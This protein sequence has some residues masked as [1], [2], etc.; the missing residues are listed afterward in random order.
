MPRN[1]SGTYS[2]PLPPVVANTVIQAAWG[3]TT[4][5]DIAQGITDSLDRQGRGGMIAP[6]RLTDG[7][8]LQPAFAFTAET[9]T[10][11][12]RES[13]G[14][15][16]VTVMGVKVGQFAAAGYKG[17][18]VGPF[19]ITRAITFTGDV[20]FTSNLGAVGNVSSQAQFLG[21][22]GTAALPSYAFTSNP[23][24]GMYRI[25][26]DTLGWSTAGVV[27]MQLDT[28]GTLG[29][30][31]PTLAGAPALAVITGAGGF[32]VDIRGRASDN[33][34]VIRLLTNDYTAQRFTVQ[35]DNT[36]G[37]IG[38]TTAVPLSFLTSGVPRLAIAA[39]GAATFN[40]EVYV[41]GAFL[42]SQNFYVGQSTGSA[43]TIGVGGGLGGSIVTW[44][45]A[46]GGVG[47]VDL[48]AVGSR[49]VVINTQ[50]GASVNWWEMTGSPAATRL[51][52][53]AKGADASLGMWC[54]TKGVGDIL[55]SGNG[56]NSLQ[57]THD[58]VTTRWFQMA[59]ATT[60]QRNP[61][62][63]V[64]GGHMAVSSGL[65]IN[66][67]GSHGSELDT[68]N[69]FINFQTIRFVD[70]TRVANARETDF[71]WGSGTFYGRFV[72]DGDSGAVNWLEVTGSSAN[73]DR[74]VLSSMTSGS[75]GV[76][77]NSAS[78]TLGLHLV[79]TGAAGANIK[80]TGDGGVTPVKYIRAQGGNFH[81][82]NNGYSGLLLAITDA[83]VLTDIRGLSLGRDPGAT[84]G[85]TPP[86]GSIVIG[87]PTG[88]ISALAGTVTPSG[89]SPMTI[90]AT[91]SGTNTTITGGTWRNCGALSS[92]SSVALWIRI[93]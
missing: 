93:A 34:A 78:S 32:G 45:N 80:L 60:L 1:V 3:N 56:G 81:I 89:G 72:N 53:Q 79:D 22:N 9:G 5:D 18:L 55:F 63:G 36:N 75:G 13:A 49:Q 35:V 74:I 44:G 66:G 47:T 30:N 57:L 43:G 24:L 25:S 62:I 31:T 41:S 42:Q 19:N 67:A 12:Y 20:S 8:V 11:L 70:M 16:S 23:N 21:G 28:N 2:L 87:S 91:G 90:F 76:T 65:R 69:I 50:A 17:N 33:L 27:R 51:T 68:S 71:L 14:I 10:G 54:I 64:T 38:T 48:N 85:T 15:L 37:Y 73:V 83:G 29:I 46:T 59:G 40:S 92:T 26:A 77:I 58:S 4:T 7:T 39:A 52:L 86:I 88:N 82:L 84:G 6:F 61:T